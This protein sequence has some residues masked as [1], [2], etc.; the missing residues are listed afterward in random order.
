[1][2]PERRMQA[3]WRG[4]IARLMQRFV[5]WCDNGSLVTYVTCDVIH[6]AI[7]PQTPEMVKHLINVWQ[8]AKPPPAPLVEKFAA[9]EAHPKPRTNIFKMF[10]ISNLS[11]CYL[12]LI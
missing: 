9:R 7:M 2:S 10:S 12:K 3:T 1:M 11:K 4:A 5:C 6:T 8:A